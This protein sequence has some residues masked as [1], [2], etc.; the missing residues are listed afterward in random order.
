MEYSSI[1]TSSQWTGKLLLLSIFVLLPWFVGAHESRP[2][3]LELSQTGEESYDVIWKIPAKGPGQRLSLNLRFSKEIQYSSLPTTTYINAA[4]V[5]RSSI[6]REGGLIGTEI[7]IEGLSRTM[8]DALVRVE[9]LDGTTQTTRLSPDKPSFVIQE[10]PGS[11]DVSKT[12]TILGVQHIFG[13]I[14]HLLFVTCLLLVAGTGRK[15]LVTITGFTLAHSVTLAMATL[16]ILRLPIPPVEAVIALSVVFLA[17]EIAR[18]DKKGLT[19]RY[20]V[21]V[22]IS[23][24]LLHGFGFA[25]VLNEIGLPQSDLPL[26]LLFFNVGVEVGQLLFIAILI[27]AFRILTISAKRI[28]RGSF[29]SAISIKRAELLATYAIGAVASFWLLQRVLGFWA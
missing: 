6:K 27:F 23:F 15:L 2:A 25:A 29:Q 9:R 4:H 11:W 20:P 14:D 19:Y 18:G 22:S 1:N 13:G 16:D 12:Y 10:T 17:T 5:E 7:Y 21:A 8:T 26:A 24:G 28:P 3:Y